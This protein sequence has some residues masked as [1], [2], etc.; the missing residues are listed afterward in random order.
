MVE[1]YEMTSFSFFLLID[2]LGVDSRRFRL[3]VTTTGKYCIAYTQVDYTRNHDDVDHKDL[4]EINYLFFREFRPLELPTFTDT[5]LHESIQE[6][7]L[8]G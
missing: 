4:A 7:N 5:M 1:S 6:L 3:R 8:S 2:G